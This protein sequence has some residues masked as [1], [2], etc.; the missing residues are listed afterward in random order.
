MLANRQIKIFIIKVKKLV[1]KKVT[2][3]VYAVIQQ[4]QVH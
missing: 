1:F 3:S 4:Y 2:T